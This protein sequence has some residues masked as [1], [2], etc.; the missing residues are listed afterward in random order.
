MRGLARILGVIIYSYKD[1]KMRGLLHDYY[2]ILYK[3]SK[4]A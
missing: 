2:I 1:K 3:S 4:A